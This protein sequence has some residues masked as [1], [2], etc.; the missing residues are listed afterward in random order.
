M[1]PSAGPADR[2]GAGYSDDVLSLVHPISVSEPR[3]DRLSLGSTVGRF[4]VLEQLGHGRTAAVYVAYDPVL[5]R[6][7]ALKLLLADRSKDDGDERRRMIGVAQALAALSH[8][9]VIAVF[10]VGQHEDDIF[11]AMELVEGQSLRQWLDEHPRP[12]REV[13][14]VCKDAGRGLAAAHGAGLVHGEFR[15]TNVLVGS[16][17]RAR[18]ID[19]GVAHAA[20]GDFTGAGEGSSHEQEVCPEAFLDD[21]Y[22]YCV[23]VFE[24]LYRTKPD[25]ENAAATALPRRNEVPRWLHAVLLRGLQSSPQSRFA[26][27]DALLQALEAD[28]S[29]RRA[30]LMSIAAATVLLSGGTA[31]AAVWQDRERNLCQGAEDALA[32]VWGAQRRA[33]VQAAVLET[34][35]AYAESVWA[36]VQPKLDGYAAAWVHAHTDAC[37]ATSLRGEQSPEVLDLRMACLHRAKVK[38]RAAVQALETADLVGLQNAHKVVEGLDGLSRCADVEALSAEVEPP[39]PGAAAAVED[40]RRALA[41]AAAMRKMGRFPEAKAALEEARV[42]LSSI[43]Y[44]PLETEVALE[45]GELLMHTGEYGPSQHALRQ[46]LQNGTRWRQ[47]SDVQKSAR[48]LLYLLGDLERRPTEGLHYLALA[49]GLSQGEEEPAMRVRFHNCLG[50]VYAVQGNLAAAE[51]EYRQARAIAERA[52]PVEFVGLA[53]SHN[54]MG[55]VR[56]AQERF[57]EAEEE[58]RRALV[59]MEEALGAEHPTTITALSNLGAVLSVREKLA[60]GEAVF[61]RALALRKKVLGPDHPDV[62][63][64]HHNLG[65]ALLDQGRYAESEVELRRSLALLKEI[66]GSDH[67]A[68]AE[69]C[70]TFHA[71]LMKLGRLDEAVE[72][73]EIGWKIHQRDGI[74][75]AQ[76]GDSAF[77][78]A[79]T[80]WDAGGDR[81]RAD[82]LAQQAILAYAELGAAA[83]HKLDEI[84]AWRRERH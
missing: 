37:E 40:A 4:L 77:L 23:T 22:S 21:Q 67:P 82:E 71:L 76:R 27:M 17:G 54:N 68:Y 74:P 15:S 1:M 9:N 7:V 30:K 59:L 63:M 72:M 57:A 56:F 70:G 29:A 46:A 58:F 62:A 84:Q 33:E 24:A 8:P 10:E 13:L 50:N 73:A 49:R 38:L 47:W 19:F 69:V 20:T 61:R 25:L 75:H 34:R 64:S 65:S 60:E 41:Q 78:L 48:N 18:V 80:L 28:P 51:V 32:A 42:I 52:V 66:R 31:G 35:A 3:S 2:D 14:A 45:A 44:G 39:A 83:K 5:N 81:A 43:S 79:R 53:G 36:H 6:R 26:T 55:G 12:W 16:D 11:I